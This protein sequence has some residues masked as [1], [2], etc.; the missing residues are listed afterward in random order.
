MKEAL[1]NNIGTNSK[2]PYYG[3]IDEEIESEHDH[4]KLFALR[5]KRLEMQ[6]NERVK[7]K[8]LNRLNKG[9]EYTVQKYVNLFTLDNTN[10]SPKIKTPKIIKK[11]KKSPNPKEKVTRVENI[12]PDE[13][14]TIALD[15]ILKK[16]PFNL[17]D[18]LAKEDICLEIYK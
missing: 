11:S 15:A 8:E 6:L 3:F 2:T 17:Y 5:R 18:E 9:K 13:L 10:P 16:M 12:A 4:R 7:I 1:L 14:K